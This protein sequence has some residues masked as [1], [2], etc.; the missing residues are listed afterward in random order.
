MKRQ[1]EVLEISGRVSSGLRTARDFMSKRAYIEQIEAKLF[2]TPYPGTLN[3]IVSQGEEGKVA[4]LKQ[5][6]GI[7]LEGFKEGEKTFGDV[8]AFRA[9][10]NGTNCAVIFPKRS[11]HTHT[12]EIIAEKELRKELR[13][14]DGDKIKVR[15]FVSSTAS[16]I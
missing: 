5:S 13:L 11:T 4:L 7:V 10:L 12:M 2:F 14:A 16:Q 15:V 6:E 9:S 1:G 8:T 3:I